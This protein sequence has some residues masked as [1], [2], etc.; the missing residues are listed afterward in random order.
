VLTDINSFSDLMLA[1]FDASF[2]SIDTVAI[3]ESPLD[4]EVFEHVLENDV[5]LIITVPYQGSFHWRFSNSGNLW[6]LNTET[7]ELTEIT[8]NGSV[9]RS[10]RMELDPIPVTPEEKVGVRDQLGWFIQEGGSVYLTRIPST[11]PVVL[12]LFAED[13]GHL[14]VGRIALEP[15]GEGRLFDVFDPDGRFL[16]T[17]RLPFRLTLHPEPIV[18]RGILYG[19]STDESGAASVVVATVERP[20]SRLQP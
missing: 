15:D 13:S 19:I 17:L 1:R 2:A 4:S 11:K 7:Y 8:P 6:T 16:G 10:E 12:G 18:R 20:G 5:R 14:W 3:P 9:L